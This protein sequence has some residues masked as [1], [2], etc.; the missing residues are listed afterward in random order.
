M[1]FSIN[2]AQL[3][4]AAS[5]VAGIVFGGVWWFVRGQ[6]THWFVT[7]SEYTRSHGN[8]KDRLEA[9]EGLLQKLPSHD[10][11]KTLGTQ[12]SAITGR[13]EAGSE[14]MNGI[15]D[16]VGRLERQLEQVVR[17]LLERKPGETS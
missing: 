17:S 5:T 7:R 6:L 3:I 15:K 9:A 12:I 16:G 2:D 4:A 13:L 10:D 1:N 14:R 11:F 8:L